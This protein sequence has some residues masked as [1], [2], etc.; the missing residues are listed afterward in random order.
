[1][2]ALDRLADLEL[3]LYDGYPYWNT[4][5]VGGIYHISQLPP[6]PEPML[7]EATQRQALVNRLPVCLVLGE[8]DA[9]YVDAEGVMTL[10]HAAPRGGFLF[11]NKL[12]PGLRGD[13]SSQDFLLRELRLATLINWQR[14]GDFGLFGDL[15]KGG[16]PATAEEKARLLGVQRDGTPRG[17]EQCGRC[18]D[19]AGVCL[20]SDGVFAGYVMTMHCRCENH[21]RCARCGGLLYER[22]LNANYYNAKDRKIWHVPG[23]CAF[24]HRCSRPQRCDSRRLED[25]IR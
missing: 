15:T 23:F 21:H 19:W 25:S 4:R 11:A 2:P 8:H 6:V 3:P 7:L 17:L 18:G 1:M 24:E 12:W 13:P 14:E 16:R 20:E 22:K 9:R 10:S 5:V